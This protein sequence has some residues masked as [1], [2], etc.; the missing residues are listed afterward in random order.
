MSEEKML[1]LYKDVPLR[2]SNYYKY[3]FTFSGIAQDGNK[4][5]ATY[6]GDHDSIYR[7]ELNVD[8]TKYI[9]KYYKEIW[10]SVRILN[11]DKEIFSWNDW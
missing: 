9:G 2:F 10:M 6:G 7:H 11:G 4:V 1:E 3:M 8:D 5:I